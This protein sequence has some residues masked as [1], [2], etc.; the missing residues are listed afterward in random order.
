M[1]KDY[2]NPSSLFNSLRYGFSQIVIGSGSRHI[3]V[4]GQTAWD[5]DQVIIGG[6]DLGLQTHQALRNLKAAV[7]SAGGTLK[8]ITMIRIYIVEGIP[9]ASSIVGPILREHFGTTAPPAST[10]LVVKALANPDFLIE[11]EAQGILE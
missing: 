9:K 3:F 10:W 8:D 4:S 1:P 11:I 6:N 2:V 7:E 5:H